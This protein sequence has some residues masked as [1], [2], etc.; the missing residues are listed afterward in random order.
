MGDGFPKDNKCMI[1]YTF[2]ISPEKYLKLIRMPG[3]VMIFDDDTDLLEVCSIVLRS[4]NYEVGGFHKCNEILHE[5]RAFSPDVILMDNWIPDAGG[6]RAT[7]QIKNDLVLKTIPVIFFSAND[8]VEDLAAEAGAEFFLQKPFEI[9]EL[10]NVVS[11]AIAIHRQKM[12]SAKSD[13]V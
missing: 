1:C 2:G 12:V 5:V 7:Q 13:S 9:E 4:K 6:V 11:K 3:R 8:R 10:E